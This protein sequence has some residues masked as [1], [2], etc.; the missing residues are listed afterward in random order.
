MSIKLQKGQR[1]NLTE[2]HDGL[3]SILIGLGW[4]P[5]KK[6][7]GFLGLLMGKAQPEIDFDASVIMLDEYGKMPNK[8]SLIYFGNIQSICESVTYTGDNLTGGFGDDE[9]I[10]IELSKVPNH[11]CK[12]VFIFNIYDCVRRNQDFGL[13]KNAYIRVVKKESNQELVKFNLS[14]DYAGKTTLIVAEIYR[15]NKNWNFVAIGKGTSNTSLDEIVQ[16]Y[17]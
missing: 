12:I 3:S 16:K 9:Q 5:I 6:N 8:D 1:I 17:K 11:I 15:H 14:D 2:D 10:I 13:I 7:V 4:D